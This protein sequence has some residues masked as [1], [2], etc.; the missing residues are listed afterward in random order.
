MKDLC[1]EK[2]I[3][4]VSPG[5][6]VKL[7]QVKLEAFQGRLKGRSRSPGGVRKPTRRLRVTVLKLD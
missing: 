7:E 3:R 4:A 5:G 1:R 2:L 6:P